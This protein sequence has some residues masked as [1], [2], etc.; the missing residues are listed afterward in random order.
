MAIR[1]LGWAMAGGL[2]AGGMSFFVPNLKRLRALLGGAIGGAV[3]AIGFI[4]IGEFLGFGD[5]P[6]RLVGAALLGFFIGVMVA[7]VEAVFREAW[8]E[9]RYGPGEVRTVSLGRDPVSIG[10][11][12]ALCTVYAANAA[13]IA[14]RYWIKDAAIFCEDVAANRTSH[15]VPGDR[16]LIGKV[17]SVVF[18][19]G[20]RARPARVSAPAGRGAVGAFV[21]QLSNGKSLALSKGATLAAADLPG[22][23]SVPPGGAV[24]AVNAHPTDPAIVGL[25]N[26]SQ[27]PWRVYLANGDSVE[28]KPGKSTRL[29]AGVK[30][31]FG[32]IRG[33]VVSK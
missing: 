27:L 19:V 16:K 21:L 20:E 7:L 23:H 10:S 28:I 3:G 22:L 1:T 26:L 6:A 14:Y 8:L 24:A 5:M 13:P 2:L 31:D 30:F 18:G 17:E 32:S 15:V 4:A 9:I 29:A 25:Q 33:E 11:N 12:Q